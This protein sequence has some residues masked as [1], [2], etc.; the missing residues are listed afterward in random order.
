MKF[1]KIFLTLIAALALVGA[2]GY[3]KTVKADQADTPETTKVTPNKEEIVRRST[4]NSP[5]SLRTKLALH[6]R[7]SRKEKLKIG[8]TM[9]LGNDGKVGYSTF[10]IGKSKM[11][12]WATPKTIYLKDGKKWQKIKVK[13]A[14]KTHRH[15]RSIPFKKLKKSRRFSLAK[16]LK[17]S[18]N[19]YAMDQ[20]FYDALQVNEDDDNYTLTLANNP[21][22][23][24]ELLEAIF[25][26]AGL[27]KK[28]LKEA[29]HLKID[30]YSR[31]ETIS[32][33]D[34]LLQAAKFSLKMH[35]RKIVFQV[36]GTT[37]GVNQY[38]NLQ[39]PQ[40]IIKHAKKAK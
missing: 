29:R 26:Y 40:T 35:Y 7:L 23:N 18:S 8:L 14:N 9:I 11:K 16:Q 12:V 3:S 4:L 6:I 28:E 1:K 31:T 17:L 15:Q 5:H 20:K 10:K 27:N 36:T 30:N 39:I 2:A 24:R 33:N 19:L 37:D 32:K 38:N 21:Q 13:A 25:K 34:Y 22:L